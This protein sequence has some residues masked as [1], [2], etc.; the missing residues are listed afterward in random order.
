MIPATSEATSP[1]A[2]SVGA[3]SNTANMDLLPSTKETETTTLNALIAMMSSILAAAMISVGMPGK[4]QQNIKLCEVGEMI[5]RNK[6][7][8]SLHQFHCVIKKPQMN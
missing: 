3:W 1:T 8:L 5:D 6:G 2:I 7:L 4:Q